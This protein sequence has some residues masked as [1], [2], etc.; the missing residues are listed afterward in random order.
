MMKMEGVYEEN[1]ETVNGNVYGYVNGQYY[2]AL[3]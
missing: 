1:N 3:C 2:A